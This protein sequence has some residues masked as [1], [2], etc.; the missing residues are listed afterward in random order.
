M[1]NYVFSNIDINLS[2]DVK[3]NRKN[4]LFETKLCCH[5]IKN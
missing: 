2:I 4:I 3:S 1:C 5:N